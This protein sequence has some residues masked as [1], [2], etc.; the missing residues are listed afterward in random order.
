MRTKLTFITMMLLFAIAS[1]AQGFRFSYD[2][3]G[4]RISRTMYFNITKEASLVDGETTLEE[5]SEEAIYEDRIGDIQF[6]IYP[7]PTTGIIRVATQN[8][9]QYNSPLRVTLYDSYGRVV[10]RKESSFENAELNITHQPAGVY[11][12]ILESGEMQPV[13]WKVVK[14]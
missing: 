7:N 13:Q 14:E 12:M 5:K 10:C 9:E 2:A 4:N 8:Q 6:Y 11:T 1:N 3:A